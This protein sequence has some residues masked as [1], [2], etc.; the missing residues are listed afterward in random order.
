MQK[1]TWEYYR[2]TGAIWSDDYHLPPGRAKLIRNSELEERGQRYVAKRIEKEKQAAFEERIHVR[3]RIKKTRLRLHARQSANAEKELSPRIS[4]SPRD[5]RYTQFLEDYKAGFPMALKN[6]DYYHQMGNLW[7]N[8]ALIPPGNQSFVLHRNVIDND[9]WAVDAIMEKRR[10]EEARELEQE[11]KR[12]ARIDKIRASFNEHQVEHYEKWKT[13][14]TYKLKQPQIPNK[15]PR[16]DRI[17]TPRS[18]SIKS[19][20]FNG[21]LHTN[22]SLKNLHDGSLSVASKCSC[23]KTNPD[24][25]MSSFES[26]IK[27][28][29]EEV[30]VLYSPESFSAP[31]NVLSELD[32]FEIRLEEFE[33]AGL[34]DEPFY[35]RK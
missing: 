3:D 1:K 13:F 22:V 6:K 29:E 9:S 26:E 11:A 17:P 28:D 7:G 33:R 25:C 27:D 23:N 30:H 32:D 21:L 34:I 20:D 24:E 16:H 19:A 14:G 5:V 35:L 8:M 31:F 10:L 2:R 12:L 18:T 4:A 15:L